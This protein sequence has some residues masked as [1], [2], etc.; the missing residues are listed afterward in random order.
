MKLTINGFL[1]EGVQ[2]GKRDYW[3]IF[4]DWLK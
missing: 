2:D 4:S 3:T 1:E